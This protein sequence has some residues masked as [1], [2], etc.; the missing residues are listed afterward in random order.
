MCAASAENLLNE[1][2][3]RFGIS[4]DYHDIWGQRHIISHDTKRAILQAMGV[5]AVTGQELAR[6]LALHDDAFWRKACDPAL[7][8]KQ[9]AI[10]GQSSQR[11]CWSFRMPALAEEERE[12][13]ILWEIWD[14]TGTLRHNGHA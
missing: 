10:V 12:I 1:L 6:A 4:P 9:S 14:E 2:A 3:E 13:Q 5:A 11:P 8:V 7:I